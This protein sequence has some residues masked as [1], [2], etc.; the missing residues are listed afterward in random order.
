ML[1]GASAGASGYLAG[2]GGGD[3]SVNAQCNGGCGGG[4][5]SKNNG[6]VNT[7]GGGGGTSRYNIRSGG[8]GIVL[9]WYII[10]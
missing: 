4:G 3:Y 8:S 10:P 7:G 2:G 9:I 6:A 5:G 1:T